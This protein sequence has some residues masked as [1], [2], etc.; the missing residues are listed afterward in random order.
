[1][2]KA[3]FVFLL[4]SFT[5]ILCV[6][7]AIADEVSRSKSPENRISLIPPTVRD[8]DVIHRVARAQ[9][10]SG[11]NEPNPMALPEFLAQDRGTTKSVSC[12]LS[13]LEQKIH[14][15]D[16]PSNSS[17]GFSLS[18][19]G[20]YAIIGMPYIHTSEGQLPGAAYIFHRSGDN[21]TQQAK[22]TPTGG[23]EWEVFGYSVSISGDY[24]VV[25]APITFS[26]SDTGAAYVFHRSGDSWIQQTRL[27][28]L[29]T[30][31]HLD[32]FGF[33]VSISGD[34]VVVG[35]AYDS[36]EVYE[37]GA[38]HIFCR[39]GTSWVKTAKLTASDA[40]EEDELGYS[41]SISGDYAIV[42][43]AGS[44]SAYIFERSGDSWTQQARVTSSDAGKGEAFGYSV[45]ISGEYAIIGA[46]YYYLENDKGA[47][48]IFNRSGGIWTQ[49]AKLKASDQ[50]AYDSFGYDVSISGD[51][52]I[53]G[54]PYD[55]NVGG[56]GAGSAYIFQRF[57]TN[58]TQQVKLRASDTMPS[59]KFGKAVSISG[60]YSV[61]GNHGNA[62]VYLYKGSPAVTDPAAKVL[63]TT[64][65][66]LGGTVSHSGWAEITSRG[67]VWSTKPNPARGSCNGLASIYGTV[68]TF[69][70]TARGLLPNTTYH[71]R[72]YAMN[73]LGTAYTEDTTFVTSG[74]VFPGSLR[75][76]ISPKG[77]RKAGA[78]WKLLG[79]STW[80]LSGKTEVGLSP[81]E[82]TIVFH[83]LKG[84]IPPANLT[85]TIQSGQLTTVNAEYFLK[86]NY[87]V[88]TINFT[89]PQAVRNGVRWR[90]LGPV[91]S[92]PKYIYSH[93]WR[94]NGEVVT[95]KANKYAIEFLPVPGWLHP[96][97]EV[98]VKGGQYTNIE[99]TSLPFLITSCSD[100]DGDGCDDIVCF[101]PTTLIWAAKDG[102]ERK[103]GSRYTWPAAGDYNGDGCADLAYWRPQGGV[104]RVNSQY[105]LMN[106][107][108]TGD[109]AV[110][111]DYDGDGKCDPTLYRR[112]KGKWLM[113]LSTGGISQD[114][115]KV[116]TL[117]FGGDSDD[118]P[119]PA[120][121]DG[122]GATEAALYNLKTGTW[123]IDGGVEVVYG[124]EGEL[125]MPGDYDGDGVA[126][127]ALVDLQAG[128]WRVKDQFDLQI[129]STTG[130]FPL[131]LDYNGDGIPEPGYYRFDEGRWHLYILC[132]PFDRNS[133]RVR[134]IDFGSDTSLPL[135]PR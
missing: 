92:H 95:L 132:N 72:A 114:N 46:P 106:F 8:A 48:Y 75:V 10:I 18:V 50:A 57:G 68:G 21:W 73:A 124:Q 91:G 70:V 78:I 118:I 94:V 52:A 88:L 104:W 37:A 41:V 54:C 108:E 23:L 7:Y 9:T 60:D 67:V 112:S 29:S 130:D 97:I 128:T 85:V 134:I 81:G 80:H 113:V 26:E 84:W 63:S 103:F 58:W 122:D 133:V 105:R 44:R 64:S 120:D 125:P 96:N 62:A 39:S 49:Q 6:E 82:Y 116:T 51:Y 4:L 83:E 45:S 65:A 101:D 109:I 56:K 42:G 14:A 115:F 35:A 110:P 16:Y 135:S 24:A 77:A 32:F 127:L 27:K 38:A 55:D 102:F 126:D 34:Y 40:E 99:V 59:E 17:F 53:I 89:I 11:L 15:S 71:Y 107:G 93:F 22:L 20:D 28:S 3:S 33:S 76:I 117:K 129:N 121:Y 79:S 98:M 31:G 47:A 69:T 119:V 123:R 66:V 43:A 131:L 19:S 25:G 87:G 61:V 111:G 12:P 1:M 36:D 2:C 13:S 86:K 100:F 5:L 90:I 74:E 30:S